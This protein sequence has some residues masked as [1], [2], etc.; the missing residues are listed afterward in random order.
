MTFVGSRFSKSA[1][2]KSNIETTQQKLM[3][4]IQEFQDLNSKIVGEKKV[5]STKE[6][7][8]KQTMTKIEQ[9]TTQ[10]VE[11][12]ASSSSSSSTSS[13]QTQQTQQS[14]KQRTAS[15]QTAASSQQQTAASSQQQNQQENGMGRL[16]TN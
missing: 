1:Q 3:K 12:A 8:I 9:V 11:T 5:S 4:N 14:Q 10:F 16:K 6:T 2:M 15:S 13:Q 7:Q